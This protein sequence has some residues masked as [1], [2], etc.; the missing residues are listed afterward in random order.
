MKYS[1]TQQDLLNSK[2]RELWFKQKRIEIKK[3][4]TVHNLDVD[5]TTPKGLEDFAKV[6]YGNY[7][8]KMKAFKNEIVDKMKSE[9][10]HDHHNAYK[11]L[12]EED[13][14][15]NITIYPEDEDKAIEMEF[16]KNIPA[17]RKV[18]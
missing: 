12:S 11:V 4:N 5:F 17:W 8:D 16:G 15:G 9:I 18:V 2:K 7:D 14:K 6:F 13:S 10:E 1:F 3:L